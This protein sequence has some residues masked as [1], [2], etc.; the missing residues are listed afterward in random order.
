MRH[1]PE[2]FEEALRYVIASKEEL[3]EHGE[4]PLFWR[5]EEQAGVAAGWAYPYQPETHSF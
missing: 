2:R 3:V 5:V 4:A 1:W